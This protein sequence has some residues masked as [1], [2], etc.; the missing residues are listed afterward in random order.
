MTDILTSPFDLVAK[1]LQIP[2]EYLNERSAMGE[3]PNWDSLNHVAIIN[4][5]EINYNISIPN[6]DM[7][8]YVTME[9]IIALYEK[10]TGR[11]K[12]PL[13]IKRLKEWF[14]HSMIMKI[15]GK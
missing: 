9:A 15:F 7:E 13:S 3:T 4:E 10:K 2:K 1:V 6:E 14:K 8:K 12:S 5:L 11:S